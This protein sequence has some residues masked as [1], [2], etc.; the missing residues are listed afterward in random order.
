ML[1]RQDSQAGS[2]VTMTERKDNNKATNKNF[3]FFSVYDRLAEKY[4][5]IVVA[6]YLA[7]CSLLVQ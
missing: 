4:T 5:S 3:M 7:S 6:D 1:K 2:A